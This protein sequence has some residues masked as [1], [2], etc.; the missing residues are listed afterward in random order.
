MF[1]RKKQLSWAKLKVGIVITLALLIVFL[2]IIFSGGIKSLLQRQET[3]KIL[4]ADVKGLRAGASVRVAGVDVGNVEEIKLHE[5][6][7]TIVTV[8]INKD[9]INFLRKDAKAS[10]QTI[11]LLGDKYV[12]IWP[13]KSQDLFDK[14]RFMEGYSQTEIKEII[15][16]ASNALVQMDRLIEK[17]NTLISDIQESKG[18]VYRFLKD[19]TLYNNFNS[20]VSELKITTNEIRSGSLGMISRDREIYQKL[21]TILSNLEK[22]SNKLNSSEGSLARLIN[23]PELYENLLSSSQKIDRLLREIE[24]SEGTLTLLLKDK[25]TASDLKQTIQE[26]KSLLEEIKKDPKKFFKFSVF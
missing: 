7:G 4:I 3:V 16:V 25:Q 5:K 9:V 23:E 26:L 8:S 1:D 2:V 14:S 24:N 12:E 22:I 17:I 18:T 20:L 13:G 10:V 6:Y 11:G 15:G 21:T 19:P